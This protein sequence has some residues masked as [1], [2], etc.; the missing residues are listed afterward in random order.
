MKISINEAD[1]EIECYNCK[2]KGKTEIKESAL[3]LDMFCNNCGT[4]LLTL[5]D[6]VIDRG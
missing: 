5:Y 3:N 1:R 4:R 6:T 2:Y